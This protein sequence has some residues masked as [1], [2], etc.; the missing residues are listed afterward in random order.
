MCQGGDF[1]R[2][3]YSLRVIFTLFEIVV[4]ACYLSAY[5]STRCRQVRVLLSASVFCAINAVLYMR[6]LVHHDCE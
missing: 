5:S 6:A 4:T 3:K 2:G 1:T